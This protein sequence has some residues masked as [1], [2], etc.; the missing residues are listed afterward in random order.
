MLVTFPDALTIVEYFNFDRYGEIVY[1]S[2]RQNT[3]PP[4]PSRATTRG[5]CWPPT[6]PTASSSTMGAPHRTR[7]RPSTPTAIRCR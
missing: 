5:P 1:A 3:P 4:S 6:R 2:T 7:A